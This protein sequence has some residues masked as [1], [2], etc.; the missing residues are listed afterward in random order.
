MWKI[1]LVLL[2][3]ASMALAQS[4][5]DGS[6]SVRHAKNENF[7]L[8]K[9]EMQKAESLY[10]NACTAV[11]REFHSAEELRPH[12]TVVVG[13][14]RNEV[15]SG[16]MKADDDLQIWMKTWNHTTFAQGVV[17]L[18]FQQLLSREVITQLGKRAVRYSN[19]T[20]DVAGFK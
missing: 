7:S 5:S 19:S 15:H 14:E 9:A 13:T 8:S 6:F 17:V 18:A 20:V 10:Q 1:A 3:L 4:S 11:Q 2:V 12:F 16:G